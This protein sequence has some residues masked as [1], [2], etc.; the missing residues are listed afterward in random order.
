MVNLEQIENVSSELI[1]IFQVDSP[2]VPLEIML[3]RPFPDMW[4]EVE[5]SLA[6]G[7]FMILNDPYRPRMSL[8]RL[9]AREIIGCRWGIERGLLPYK[10]D[11]PSLS[12]LARAVTMP[13][14][15]VL[16]LDPAAQ[17][18][19]VMSDYFEVPIKDV[20]RRLEDLNI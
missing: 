16:K 4:E 20:I 1:A 17:V 3:Q 9:L 19:E 6:S 2:P 11:K 5:I 7:S 15:M 8:A 10:G 14:S 12:A 13:R 18:P